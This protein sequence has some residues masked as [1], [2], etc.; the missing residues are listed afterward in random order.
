ME[1]AGTKWTLKLVCMV[2]YFILM[3]WFMFV[4][5]FFTPGSPLP[6]GDTL[7]NIVRALVFLY[8]LTWMYKWLVKDDPRGWHKQ[9][10][11]FV[12]CGFV[13]RILIDAAMTACCG[14]N[15]DSFFKK[16]L[17]TDFLN[18]LYVVGI[19]ILLFF[20]FGRRKILL[21]K[22]SLPQGASIL[23][24]AAVIICLIWIVWLVGVFEAFDL[25]RMSAEDILD[26]TML[27]L[28]GISTGGDVLLVMSSWVYNLETVIAGALFFL[29]WINTTEGK[30][31]KNDMP[32]TKNIDEL[33]Y[34][35]QPVQ[36]AI[37]KALSVI[38]TLLAL[39]APIGKL[40]GIIIPCVAIVMELAYLVN[41]RKTDGKRAAVITCA[42]LSFI[43]LFVQIF[44]MR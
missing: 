39:L 7:G 1:K 23:T 42:V 24:T 16:A 35:K 26:P 22:K 19:L 30:Q 6:I 15:A 40:A 20:V 32:K 41:I 44:V 37:V 3:S 36:W 28:G 25:R 38:L 13:Y 27:W 10:L 18:L 11:L 21:A 17:E 4:A 31:Q 9:S 12:A 29:L 14:N 34:G 33:F 8:S 43:A 5:P 2:V